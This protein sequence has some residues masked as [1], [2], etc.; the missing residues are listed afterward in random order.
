MLSAVS[1]AR[2]RDRDEPPE[3]WR[4]G[5]ALWCGLALVLFATAPAPPIPPALQVHEERALQQ[6]L[7]RATAAARRWQASYGDQQIPWDEARGHLAIV[8]DDVGR[9][10]HWFEQL[11]ALRH[12]LTFSV[13]PGSVYAPGAQLRLSADPRRPREIWLH[14]PTEPLDPVHMRAPGEA[15]EEFLRVADSPDVLRDKLNRALDRVPLAVGVNNHMG[16]RLTAER[17]AMDAL[18]PELRAR[19]LMFLDSLTIG[20]SQAYAAARDAGVPATTRAVFLDHV[21]ERAEIEARLEEAATRARERPTVVIGHP[22][23]ALV[24]VLTERLDELAE[25][26]IGVYP[27]GEVIAHVNDPSGRSTNLTDA[28]SR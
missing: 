11:L 8:I 19:G 1:D 23:Q 3:R 21:P 20:R 27:L 5:L 28:A 25:R 9:E 14:L 10:L 26:G 2:A 15:D 22:S 17:A 12:P 16:S 24:D 18:M 7:A 6:E 4:L 13:L